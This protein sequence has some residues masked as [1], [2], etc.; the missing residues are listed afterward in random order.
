M[1]QERLEVLLYNSIV[2]LLEMEGID[3][4][5]EAKIFLKEEI[6]MSEDEYNTIMK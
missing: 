2:Y 1:K 6:G 3:A 4:K 5:D